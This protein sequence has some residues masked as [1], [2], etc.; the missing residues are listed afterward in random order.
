[1]KIGWLSFGHFCDWLSWSGET[2]YVTDCVDDPYYHIFYTKFRCSS[3]TASGMGL[4]PWA[5][6]Y[7][8]QVSFLGIYV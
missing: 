2:G 3:W 1:M 6:N 4:T 7:T 5:G 8:Q